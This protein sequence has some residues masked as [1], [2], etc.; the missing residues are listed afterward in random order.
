MWSGIFFCV[1]LKTVDEIKSS[2]CELYSRLNVEEYQLER[3]RELQSQLADLK[4]QIE[5]F[6]QVKTPCLR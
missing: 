2:I 3:E 4:T 1:D 5:P 6:E